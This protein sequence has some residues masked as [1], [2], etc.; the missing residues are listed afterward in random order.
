AMGAAGGDALGQHVDVRQR[1]EVTALADAT[2]AEYGRVDVLVNNVGHY[3]FR[4]TPFLETD[5]EHWDSLYA[6]NL[7]HMFLCTKAFAPR[8]VEQAT[9]AA[10]STSRPSRRSEASRRWP[11]TPRSRRASRSS[12]RAWR[13]GSATTAS[14]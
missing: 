2:L 7:R 6:V 10:S 5:E 12:R 4:A 11:C 1:D 14:A 13:S 8:M 9:A 3:L